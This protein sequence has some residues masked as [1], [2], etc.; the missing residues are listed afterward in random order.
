MVVKESENMT[1]V[2]IYQNNRNPH[3]YIEVH[4]DGH[5]HNSVRQFIRTW[6]IKRKVIVTNYTGDGFLHRWRKRDLNQLFE[7]YHLHSI[8]GNLYEV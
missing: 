7:D 2:F 5:S 8:R 6:C 4:D 3:K 1:N